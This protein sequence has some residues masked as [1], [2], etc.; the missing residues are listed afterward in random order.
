MQIIPTQSV[1]ITFDTE[2]IKR[3]STEIE[4]NFLVEYKINVENKIV[5]DYEILNV[6]KVKVYNPS[7][8]IKEISNKKNV[9]LDDEIEYEITINNNG[10]L[11]L[12]NLTV[13]DTL[14]N[15]LELIDGSCKINNKIVN[16]VQLSK[17]ITIEKLEINELI[18]IKYNAKVVSGASGGKIVNKAKVRY[19]YTL[20]N[21]VKYYKES[22]EVKCTI[23][24][25]ISNFKQISINDCICLNRESPLIREINDVN[26]NVNIDTFKVIKTPIAKSKGGQKLSGYKLIV[27]GN[28]EE[29]IE[30]IALNEENTVNSAKFETPFSTYIILPQDFILG[31]HIDIVG[32]IEKIKADKINEKKLYIGAELL[33][34]AKMASH[35]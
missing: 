28:V 30:F 1:V 34:I 6:N 11:N 27:H 14:P 20:G 32:F 3:I 31:T 5:Q 24:M 2:I 29:V 7:V 33:I 21:K 8:K 35:R 22:E 13:K 4:V 9:Q 18:N 23:K 19:S 12:Y 17:G 15:C 10:D 25:L 26:A 16:S